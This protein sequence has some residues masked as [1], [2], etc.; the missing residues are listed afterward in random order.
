MRSRPG[1]PFGA[2]SALA[3]TVTMFT[4]A[5]TTVIIAGKDDDP[6]AGWWD[7]LVR[8]SDQVL[9]QWPES[10]IELKNKSAKGATHG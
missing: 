9:Q 6:I 5:A 8:S 1:L 3:A 10:V 4:I 7:C 2:C